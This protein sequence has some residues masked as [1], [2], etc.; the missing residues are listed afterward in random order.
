MVKKNKEKE[1]K[2]KER[3]KESKKSGGIETNIPSSILGREKKPDWS[4]QRTYEGRRGGY[5]LVSSQLVSWGVCYSHG[6][7]NMPGV[8]GP[9]HSH[10]FLRLIREQNFV[11][12]ENEHHCHFLLSPIEKAA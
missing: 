12:C 2:E 4:L 5:F 6:T 11:L 10:Y 3:V 9:L 1:K 8:M 7:S